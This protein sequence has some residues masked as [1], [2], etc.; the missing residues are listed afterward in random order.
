[1]LGHTHMPLDRP[2]RSGRVVNPG[3]VGQPRDADARAAWA[4]LDLREDGTDP[5]P[6]FRRVPYDVEG[7]QDAIRH[8]GLPEMLAV[9]LG[10]GI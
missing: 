1:V 7:A 9:R 6:V 2:C 3:S 5:R 4:Y 8:A 10:Q